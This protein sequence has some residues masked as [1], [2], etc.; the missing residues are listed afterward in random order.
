MIKHFYTYL[1]T[2]SYNFELRLSYP[3][4]AFCPAKVDGSVE[5]GHTEHHDWNQKG[6]KGYKE[7]HWFRV[8]YI[9]L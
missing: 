6:G 9:D 2:V 1:D 4:K 3:L 7:I 8:E 5:G